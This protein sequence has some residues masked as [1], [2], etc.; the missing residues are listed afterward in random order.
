MDRASFLRKSVLGLSAGLVSSSV[1]AACGQ[2]NT[3]TDSSASTTTDDINTDPK[4]GGVYYTLD[5]PG[6]WSKKAEGHAPKVEL[7]P[8]AD[9]K[10]KVQVVTT[11]PM[12]GFEHYIIKH[13]LLDASF[14][15]LDEN[16]FDPNQDSEPISEFTLTG[17]TGP[18]YALS[19]CNLH[20]VWLSQINVTA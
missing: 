18:L 7:T 14:G 13:Q 12:K 16:L 2:Q 9:Q 4:A 11:H 17:Y 1:I 5:A 6:R 15:Y 19:F 20:D 8:M 3:Q 10:V